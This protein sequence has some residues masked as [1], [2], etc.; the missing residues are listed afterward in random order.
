[1]VQF[2]VDAGGSDNITAVLIPYA[3]EES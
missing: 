2:A 1:M 3:A